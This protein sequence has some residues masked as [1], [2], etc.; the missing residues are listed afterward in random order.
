LKYS[1]NAHFNQA[2]AT[3]QYLKVVL[4]QGANMVFALNEILELLGY[5][6]FVLGQLKTLGQF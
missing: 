1:G 3:G 4:S 2:N 6:P 5:L